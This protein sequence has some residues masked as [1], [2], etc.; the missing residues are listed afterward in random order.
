M[1]AAQLHPLV[2][3]AAAQC[4]GFEVKLRLQEERLDGELDPAVR[5][6]LYELVA[7]TAA[8]LSHRKGMLARLQ[9]KLNEAIDQEAVSP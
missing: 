5:E 4:A 8:A 7:E 1:N 6:V 9:E 3:E 2:E